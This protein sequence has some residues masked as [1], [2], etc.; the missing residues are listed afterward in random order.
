MEWHGEKMLP[1]GLPELVY[2]ITPHWVLRDLKV[3]V[4]PNKGPLKRGIWGRCREANGRRVIN[5][6]P[7]VILTHTYNKDNIG[8]LSF[9]FWLGILEVMLH[10]IGHLVTNQ[11]LVGY[12]MERYQKEIGYYSYVE[13]SADIWK[14][15]MLQRIADRH[16]RMGQPEGWIGGLP[17]IYISRYS[18]YTMKYQDDNISTE[19]QRHIEDIRAYRCGGQLALTHV[20]TKFLHLFDTNAFAMRNIEKRLRRIVK[21]IA[22]GLGIHRHY[23][24]RAGRKHLFFNVGEVNRV[25]EELLRTGA[26]NG[27]LKCI[28]AELRACNDKSEQLDVDLPDFFF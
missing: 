6:Y 26:D 18:K 13:T 23:I 22:P 28:E 24:D 20:T 4:F 19:N 9:R 8:V 15:Q 3:I 7:T 16:P 14:D 10:E 17:G 12:S 2:Q 11:N 25:I 27:L 21:S 1:R 5:L